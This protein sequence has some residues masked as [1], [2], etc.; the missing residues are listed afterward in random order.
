MS[1]FSSEW[2]PGSLFQK[3]QSP[4][5]GMADNLW[6][7]GFTPGNGDLLCRG[8]ENPSGSTFF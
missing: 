1:A 4:R 7:P 5:A 6:M 3:K 2:M 8:I